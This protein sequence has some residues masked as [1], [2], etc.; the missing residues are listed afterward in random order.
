MTRGAVALG[1]ALLAAA[2]SAPGQTRAFNAFRPPASGSDLLGTERAMVTPHL[3]V[4]ALAVVDYTPRSGL[5]SGELSDRATL[6]ATVTLGLFDRVQLGVGL[7]LVLSQRGGPQHPA[8]ELGDVALDAR[9]RVGGDAARGLWRLALATTV[10]VPTGPGYLL[11]PGQP[12]VTPRVL[13]ELNHARDFVLAVNAGARLR[14]GAEHLL[15]ARLAA[16]VALAPRALLVAE[17][18]LDT[19]LAEPFAKGLTALEAL[20]GIHLTLRSGLVLGGAA[21]GGLIVGEGAAL[22]TRFLALV[23]FSP[24]RSDPAAPGDRDADGVLDGD[25]GCPDEPAGLRPD[26]ARRGCPRRDRDRDAVDDDRDRCPDLA[27]GDDP[28]PERPGCPRDDRDGDGVRDGDDL[29]PLEPTGDRADRAHRGCPLRDGDGDGFPDDDDACPL[30]PAGERPDHA[31]RGCPDDD[32]DD[33]G[34]TDPQDACPDEPGPRSDDPQTRGCPRVHVR[35]ERIVILQQPR[36]ATGRD[37]ILPESFALLGEVAAV[38]EARPE[39]A[40]VEVAGHTDNVGDAPRNLALSQR[41]AES[42]R[43]WLVGHGVAGERLA[44]RGYGM[45]RPMVDNATPHG[46][47]MNRRVEFVIVERRMDAPAR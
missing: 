45:E 18:A 29:C 24:P 4:G 10:T 3:R 12:T 1:L 9:V 11:A 30:T 33:D 32:R 6:H 38:L 15:T 25:D 16:S 2:P 37:V 26:P 31:H 14:P 47:A 17:A 23:G 43:R 42:V 8:P 5:R 36:F 41:R 28:D 20:A 40:R 34:V 35:G 44:A 46:R 19:P 22:D 7:P 39:L 13:F 27:R 21:G